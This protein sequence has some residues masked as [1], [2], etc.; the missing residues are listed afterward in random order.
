MELILGY[1]LKGVGVVVLGMITAAGKKAID[2]LGLKIT[3]E[4]KKIFEDKIATEIYSV[5]EKVAGM[6]KDG[7]SDKIVKAKKDELQKG[8]IKTAQYLDKTLSSIDAEK[9]VKDVVAIL[10]DIG[11]FK[12]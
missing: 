10:P 3:D 4:Q 11:A 8:V 1:V 9:V 6:I 12:F 2:Y 7:I 5:E